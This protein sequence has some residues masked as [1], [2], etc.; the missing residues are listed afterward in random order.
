MVPPT[1]P[2]LD[3]LVAANGWTIAASVPAADRRSVPV[4]LARN[5][6]A[7]PLAYVVGRAEVEADDRMVVDR[8]ARVDPRRAVLMSHDPLDRAPRDEPRQQFRPVEWA[9][10]DPD[11]V[12]LRVATTGPGLLV[13]ASTWMP[14]WTARVDGTIATVERGNHAQQVIALPEAG[15]H[16]VVLT[17][18]APGLAIG[19]KITLASVIVLLL[20]GVLGRRRNRPI[21]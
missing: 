19:A 5:P 13:V 17:Y 4:Q 8:L 9:S 15:S 3:K 12:V 7:L 11:R 20:L 21:T 6:A 18:T 2:R 16:E 14:G 10:L 1:C